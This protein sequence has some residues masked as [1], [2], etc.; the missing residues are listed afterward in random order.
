[1]APEKFPVRGCGG[2]EKKTPDPSGIPSQE[3][4]LTME[5]K[6]YRKGMLVVNNIKGNS[7]I[8]AGHKEDRRKAVYQD[9]RFH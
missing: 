5:S 8:A 6:C 9:E 4:I 2:L 7:R 3:K 1:M